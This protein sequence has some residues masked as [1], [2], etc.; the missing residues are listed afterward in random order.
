MGPQAEKLAEV[1]DF[2]DELIVMSES[3][4]PS[5]SDQ[6]R[7]VEKVITL[8]VPEEQLNDLIREIRRAGGAGLSCLTTFAAV[9][10]L[11]FLEILV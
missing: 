5:D 9:L 1:P 4:P 11:L 6:P 2:M 10:L 8:E 3:E 7:K